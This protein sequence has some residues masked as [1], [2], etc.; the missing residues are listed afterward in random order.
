[1]IKFLQSKY[2][3]ITVYVLI[4][5]GFGLC[6]WSFNS[7]QGT[8]VVYGLFTKTQDSD[9]KLVAKFKSNY[10][11]NYDGVTCYYPT[12][13]QR[14]CDFAAIDLYGPDGTENTKCVFME[15]DKRPPHPYDDGCEE[16]SIK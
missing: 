10:Y 6:L 1:M 3:V 13:A 5:A 9:W 7:A 12:E 16:A 4:V 14:S 2:A 11:A 8:L 15:G